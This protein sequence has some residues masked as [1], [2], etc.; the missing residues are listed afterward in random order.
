MTSD[1]ERPARTGTGGPA[2]RTLVVRVAGDMDPEHAAGGN[3]G[4]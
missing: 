1:E 4:R 2:R 3:P